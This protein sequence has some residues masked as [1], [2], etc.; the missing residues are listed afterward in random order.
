MAESIRVR[1]TVG[2]ISWSAILAGVVVAF[3]LNAVLNLIGVGVGLGTVDPASGETPGPMT[4]GIGAGVWWTISG[5]LALFAGGW[6]A[7]HLAG[8]LRE[9][10]GA[11]HGLIT[12][13]TMGVLSLFAL[14]TALGPTFG[15]ALGALGSAASTA[16]AV[17]AGN[18]ELEEQARQVADGV[19]RETEDLRTEAQAREAAEKSAKATSAAALWA[20]IAILLG[21]G[22]AA[23]GGKAGSDL[24][25]RD[26]RDR[27]VDRPVTGPPRSLG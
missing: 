5:L 6:V 18:G 16:T 23:F 12:W 14:S 22:A 20:A 10:E 1:E 21:A 11:W 9:G 13:A 26:L 27:A 17:V 15:G 24:R 25:E 19:S 8:P 2:R 4:I 7:A 3:L